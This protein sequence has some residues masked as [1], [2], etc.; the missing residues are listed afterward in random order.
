MVPA[1]ELLNLI[2]ER[3]SNLPGPV[4]NYTRSL[5]RRGNAEDDWVIAN[6]NVV[7]VQS[8]LCHSVEYIHQ[9]ERQIGQPSPCARP[10][11]FVSYRIHM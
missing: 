7:G 10:I 8:K 4:R 9:P 11:N 6:L 3:W 2:F 5:C 1:E